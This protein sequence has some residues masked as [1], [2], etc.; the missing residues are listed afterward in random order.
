MIDL[1][2]IILYEDER[3][4][5]ITATGVPLAC[6]NRATTAD[7]VGDFLARALNFELSW[8]GALEQFMEIHE[9]TFVADEP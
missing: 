9:I 4:L 2:K 6:L 7:D 1:D 8:P 5:L 3:G